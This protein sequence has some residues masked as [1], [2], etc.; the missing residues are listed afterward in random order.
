MRVEGCYSCDEDAR[1]DSPPRQRVHLTDHWRVAHAFDT[2]LPG[3]LVLL[4]R[5]HLRSLAELDAL[6]ADELGPLLTAL[7]RALQQVTGCVKTYVILLAEA[8]GFEHLHFHVVPRMPD[9]AH[10]ERGPRIF[11]R[12][13]RPES[14]RVPVAEMDRLSDRIREALRR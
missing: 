14:E 3:W 9:Q 1:E 4:P 7:T 11:A 10:E 2:S 8:E 13:G 5:R 6:E 12:L